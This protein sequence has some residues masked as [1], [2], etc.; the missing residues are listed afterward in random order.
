M[1]VSLNLPK[2][3]YSHDVARQ[4][5]KAAAQMPFDAVGSTLKTFT[6]ASVLKR[7]AEEIVQQAAQDFEE[8]YT[9]T[10]FDLTQPTG[11]LLV[12]SF[13]QK[14]VVMHKTNLHKATRKASENKKP[15]LDTRTSKGE[16]KRG[17][18]R[19]A[20]IAAVY[21]VA[22]FVRTAAEVIAGLKRVRIAPTEPR[23]RPEFK[24]VW[25]SLTRSPEMVIAEV[26]AEVYKRGPEHK[27]RWLVLVDGCFK[28]VWWVWAEVK[29]QGVAVT[30][31]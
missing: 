8:F 3:L 14:G 11:D 5:T 22:P 4:V 29:R 31:V 20:T 9:S 30:L 6:G 12:L 10:A 28:L 1:D 7:Q 27:K 16:V 26:F 17:H 13:D 18:K 15:K 23:P 25:A 21:T 19:M 2:F 24:R